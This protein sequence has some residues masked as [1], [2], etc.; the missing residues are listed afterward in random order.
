MDRN[1]RC[2]RRLEAGCRRQE[3]GFVLIV[4]LMIVFII[5]I[6]SVAMIVAMRSG[7]S[8]AGNIAFRQT[9]VRSGDVAVSIVQQSLVNWVQLTGNDSALFADSGQHGGQNFRYYATMDGIDSDCAKDA[10]KPFSPDNYRFDKRASDGLP[11]AA[12]MPMIGGYT[13]YYVVHRIAR[14]AGPCPAAGCMAPP[15]N[16]TQA[17]N[18]KDAD[19]PQ[20]PLNN[21]LAYYRVTVK[22]T[23]PRQNSY[24]QNFQF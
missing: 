3:S 7:I 18:S 21:T 19:A 23:A 8:A 13:L 12:Q 11:C 4:T 9:A 1:M 6:S 5:M 14:L 16:A 17:G 10:S 2:R 24:I 22:T 20:F 15:S